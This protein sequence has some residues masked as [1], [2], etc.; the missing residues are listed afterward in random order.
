[1]FVVGGIYTLRLDLI[2]HAQFLVSGLIGYKFFK[3][4]QKVYVLG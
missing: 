4:W 3:K 1:L 2:E